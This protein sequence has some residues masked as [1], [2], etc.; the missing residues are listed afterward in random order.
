MSTHVISQWSNLHILSTPTDLDA[1]Q[2]V[3]VLQKQFVLNF[4]HF[5]G[6]SVQSEC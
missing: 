6:D 1:V 3:Q 5:Q 4:S 2:K